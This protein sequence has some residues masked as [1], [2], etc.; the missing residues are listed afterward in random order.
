MNE[1]PSTAKAVPASRRGALAGF[2]G[3]AIET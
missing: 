2:F 3:T 1:P